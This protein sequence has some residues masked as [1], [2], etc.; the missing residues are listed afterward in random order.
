MSFIFPTAS[1][2][3]VGPLDLQTPLAPRE[4]ETDLGLF[5]IV[6][7][8]ATYVVVEYFN[9]NF[10]L[11]GNLFELLDIFVPGDPVEFI[12]DR[13]LPSVEQT[14]IRDGCINAFNILWIL[15][16]VLAVCCSCSC[17]FY[18]VL[19]IWNSIEKQIIEAAEFR[20]LTYIAQ[21]VDKLTEEEER[22]LYPF[23]MSQLIAEALDEDGDDLENIGYKTFYKIADSFNFYLR[24]ALQDPNVY[25]NLERKLAGGKRK[26]HY[27]ILKIAIAAEIGRPY[28]KLYEDQLPVEI[29]LMNDELALDIAYNFMMSGYAFVTPTLAPTVWED[30]RILSKETYDDEEWP[31]EIRGPIPGDES[32]VQ[33]EI[34]RTANGI[35]QRAVRRTY[36]VGQGLIEIFGGV[37]RGSFGIVGDAGEA[38]PSY[39]K[40]EKPRNLPKKT[41]EKKIPPKKILNTTRSLP[42]KMK[43]RRR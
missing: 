39:T 35:N 42:I 6:L 41:E 14:D 18:C 25:V 30:M 22:N 2:I 9:L 4:L 37:V 19:T 24:E 20:I 17:F 15:L 11:I 33:Q 31:E 29:Q 21:M 3:S 26:G 16:I 10:W 13:V 32:L 5:C 8:Y 27:N 23:E 34:D 43:K 28:I 7:T 40:V 1:P 38:P 12:P 36:A